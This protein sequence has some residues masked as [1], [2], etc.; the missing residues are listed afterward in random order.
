MTDDGFAD[1]LDAAVRRCGNPV[2]VGLDPRAESLPP[3]LIPSPGDWNALAEGFRVFCRDVIDVVAPLVPAVKPQAAFFEQLGPPGMAAL[4]DLVRY[5][6]QRG[7][8]VILDGKRNDIGSTAA[9]YAEGYLGRDGQSPWGADA[10]TV[11]PYLGDDS[12]QPFVETAVRRKAGVFVLVKTSNPGGKMLQ[13]LVVAG[14]PVYRHLGEYVES[15]AAQTAG[16]S[17]YGAVG[18]VVGATYPDQLV[19]L[20][21]AMPHTW[22]LVPGFGAQGATARDVAGAFDAHG[23]GAIVNNSRGIIFAYSAPK[24]RGMAEPTRWQS[25]VERATR[26]MIAQLRAETPAARLV[27]AG[28][29]SA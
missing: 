15:L 6:Q 5:A 2:L 13:D 9:A 29:P 10:M 17:G 4:A 27:P 20:R 25:A 24:Y 1:Q 18:A 19:E 8:L 26:D 16:A 21:R 22:F 7:L 11:S 14:R 28:S 23:R 3:G 12:L